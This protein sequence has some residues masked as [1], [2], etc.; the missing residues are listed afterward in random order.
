MLIKEYNLKHKEVGQVPE[1]TD[2]AASTQTS[3]Q[4]PTTIPYTQSYTQNLKL[5]Q[6]THIQ[7]TKRQQPKRWISGS[8]N[9]TFF[10]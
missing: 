6:P 7:N 9:D 10:F 8:K 2:A 4:D 1:D 5:I 3:I